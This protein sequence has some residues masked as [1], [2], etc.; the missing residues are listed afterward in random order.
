MTE[1]K[2]QLKKEITKL[3][4]KLASARK[5]NLTIAT[6]ITVRDK[7]IEGCRKVL[8]YHSKRLMYAAEHPWMK[9]PYELDEEEQQDVLHNK[10]S[11]RKNP[12]LQ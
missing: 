10:K 1:T 11:R 9:T 5:R 6:R 12:T 2:E 3:K 4:A 7:V 8:A